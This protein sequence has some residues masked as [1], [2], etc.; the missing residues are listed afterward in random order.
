MQNYS[1]LIRN[2]YNVK[3]KQ[4]LLTFFRC[5]HKQTSLKE[6]FNYLE[7]QF[8]KSFFELLWMT[9]PKKNELFMMIKF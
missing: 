6:T 3:T 7:Q 5:Y 2:F 8:P 9:R 1:D 4:I